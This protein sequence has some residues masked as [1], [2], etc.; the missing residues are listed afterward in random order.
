VLLKNRN[1]LV[2]WTVNVLG[3]KTIY[4]AELG[5]KGREKEGK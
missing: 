4:N 5:N 2:L 1:G 3:Y